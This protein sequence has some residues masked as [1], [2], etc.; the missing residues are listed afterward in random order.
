MSEAELNTLE[1]DVIAARARFA[2]NLARVRS[3]DT[4]AEFKDDVWG[5]VTDAKSDAIGKATD[6]VND[7]LADVKG[8]I[9]ANPVAVLAIGAGLAWR[10]SRHP[11]IASML[12]GFGLWSLWRTEPAPEGEGYLPRAV[13]LANTARDMAVTA[14]DKVEDWSTQASET[15]SQLAGQAA[16]MADQATTTVRETVH[17]LR[18][19]A[20]AAAER[21]AGTSRDTLRYVRRESELVTDRTTALLRDHASDEATRNS[22][23]LGAAAMAVTAAVGIAYQRRQ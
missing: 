6:G 15:V 5:K 20:T 18:D 2:G 9:S 10:L 3:P 1:R 19:S 23:L 22:L 13:E 7:V 17:D 4:L 14:K 11:P 12:V 21:V 16:S 8:R